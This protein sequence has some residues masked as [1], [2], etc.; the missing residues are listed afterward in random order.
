[1]NNPKRCPKCGREP[2]AITYS[3]YLSAFAGYELEC[4]DCGLHTGKCDSYEEAV[5]KWNELV[6]MEEEE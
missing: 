6:E 3:N 5:D 4:Y 1:M 2:S